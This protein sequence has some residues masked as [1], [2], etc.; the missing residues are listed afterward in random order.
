MLISRT[1][2]HPPEK[3]P[4][5]N[6]HAFVDYNYGKSDNPIIIIFTKKKKNDLLMNILV[7]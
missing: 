2:P 5:K 7:I 3:K 4:T 1:P 6:C